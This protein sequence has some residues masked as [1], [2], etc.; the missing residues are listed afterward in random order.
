M[1]FSNAAIERSRPAN[2][3]RRLRKYC[4]IDLRADF[5]PVDTLRQ[6]SFGKRGDH[7]EDKI[8]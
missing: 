1:P 2:C 8:Y 3:G 4:T 5:G 6:W 7:E